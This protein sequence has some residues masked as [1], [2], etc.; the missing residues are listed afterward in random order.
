M[1]A[2]AASTV[3]RMADHLRGLATTLLDAQTLEEGLQ[4]VVEVASAQLEP[5]AG[6]GITL[7]RDGMRVGALTVASSDALVKVVDEA[8]YSNGDGPCLTALRTARIV[9]VPDRAADPRWPAVTAA[10][11]AAGVAAVYSYP[12]TVGAD[13]VGALNV[14]ADRV[15]HF[16]DTITATIAIMAVHI[17]VL[18]A[19]LLQ[20]LTQVALTDQLTEVV[21]RRAVVD[22]AIGVIMARNRCSPSVAFDLLREASNRTNT[23]LRTLAE[24]LIAEASGQRAGRRRPGPAG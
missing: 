22:Q 11:R 14:Y 1:G 24:R 4:R 2:A 9:D 16:D 13:T 19:L 3:T 23:R 12:L 21:G 15:G 20:R 7:V 5:V 8:Q 6:C 18:L 17:E 10:A